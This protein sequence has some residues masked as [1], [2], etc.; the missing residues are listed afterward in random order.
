MVS[1]SYLNLLPNTMN[2]NYSQWSKA[3]KGQLMTPTTF[4]ILKQHYLIERYLSK[5]QKTV[6]TLP[7]TV[8]K[9]GQMKSISALYIYMYMYVPWII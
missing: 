4:L 8:L 9:L 6:L 1:C 7:Y 5:L 3:E 2:N